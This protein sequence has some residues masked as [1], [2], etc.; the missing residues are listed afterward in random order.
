MQYVKMMKQYVN[1]HDYFC[2]NSGFFVFFF[3]IMAVMVFHT[4]K[5]R[6]VHVLSDS[7]LSYWVDD[8]KLFTTVIVSFPLLFMSL[9]SLNALSDKMQDKLLLVSIWLHVATEVGSSYHQLCA[10]HVNAAAEHLIFCF[11][12]GLFW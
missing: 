4:G 7:G 10:E 2:F 5:V 3:P 6:C 1:I 9:T 11:Q 12:S 8:K